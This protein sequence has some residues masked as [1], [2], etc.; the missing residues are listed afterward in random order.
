MILNYYSNPLILQRSCITSIPVIPRYCCNISDRLILNNV[1]E[2]QRST[3][4]LMQNQQIWIRTSRIQSRSSGQIIRTMG[5][6]QIVLWSSHFQWIDFMFL[7]LLQILHWTIYIRFVRKLWCFRWKFNTELCT[8]DNLIL[9][10]CHLHES[11]L[12]FLPMKQL[13]TMLNKCHSV[14]I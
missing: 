1:L 12:K 3:H 7:G 2:S 6:I 13:G 11:L 14:F 9:N 5:I 8:E 10:F 4:P